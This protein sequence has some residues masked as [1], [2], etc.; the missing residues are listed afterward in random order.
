MR[1]PLLR[2]TSPSHFFRGSS[3]KLIIIFSVFILLPG[4]FLGIFALRVLLLQRLARTL[5]KAGSLEEA[6]LTY[7]DLV[8]LDPVSIEGLPSDLLARSE[9][10]A[11]ASERG[12]EFELGSRALALYRDLVSGVWLIQRPRYLYYADR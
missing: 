6:A 12:D 10:C 3:S 7:Q 2:R 1:N 5:R 8:K 4:I 11:L 9:L